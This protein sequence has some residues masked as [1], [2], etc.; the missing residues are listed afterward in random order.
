MPT[1][2]ALAARQVQFYLS[3]GRHA[4][5]ELLGKRNDDALRAANVVKAVHV[6]VLGDFAYELSTMCAQAR[7]DVL[8]IVDG[9]HDSVYL[10]TRPYAQ[11]QDNQ[12]VI[13]N[14]VDYP[15]VAHPHTIAWAV[16]KLGYVKMLGV[17]IA[18]SSRPRRIR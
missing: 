16:L 17:R 13:L 4:L 12:L 18:R 6:L 2:V 1:R 5:S 9:E 7:E 11:H 8:D 14:L 15:P 10:P 3:S